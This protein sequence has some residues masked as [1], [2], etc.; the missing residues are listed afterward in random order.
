MTRFRLL[1][2]G[3]PDYFDDA[4]VRAVLGRILADK[5]ALTLVET[6]QRYGAEAA[7]HAWAFENGIG[8]DG[9][10]KLDAALASKPDGAVVFSLAY[11]PCR[12]AEAIKAAGVPKF[13]VGR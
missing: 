8:S 12:F 10:H 3:G 5:G 4:R 7:V 6:T 13:E 1:V 2:A 9:F 11:H